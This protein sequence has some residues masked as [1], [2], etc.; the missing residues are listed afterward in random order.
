[1]TTVQ[2]GGTFNVFPHVFLPLFLTGKVVFAYIPYI[3]YTLPFDAAP[4]DVI[5]GWVGWWGGVRD[6]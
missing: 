4:T 3:P 1:M 5:L 2:W 6:L